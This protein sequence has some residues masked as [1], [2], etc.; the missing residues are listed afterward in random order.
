MTKNQKLKKQ[1]NGVKC[2]KTVLELFS[3]MPRPEHLK[4]GE[5]GVVGYP[6]RQRLYSSIRKAG[7]QEV[8]TTG[9]A[10]VWTKGSG[11]A[12]RLHMWVVRVQPS[13]ATNDGVMNASGWC[14]SVLQAACTA[15]EV[16]T[17]FLAMAE[18]PWVL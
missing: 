11:P 16:L 8:I 10:D 4:K 14:K 7:T 1:L 5:T 17:K 9:Q 15:N 3:K 6:T 18:V 2:S 13:Q 12:K